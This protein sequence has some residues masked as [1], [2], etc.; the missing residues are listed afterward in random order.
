MLAFLIRW[1]AANR[2]WVIGAAILLA[3]LG[4]WTLPR[5]QMDAI[6]D[7]SE[8]QVIVY[9][10]WEQPPGLV[11][12]QI[13]YPLT[14]ALLGAPKVTSVRGFSDSGFALIY[15]L[16]EEGTDLYWARS[17]ITELL[18]K[19]NSALPAGARVEMGPDATGVGWIYQYALVDETGKRSLADL[20]SIQDSSLRYALQATPGV[21][22]IATVGGFEKEYQ[23]VVQPNALEQYNV[24]FKA[25]VEAV[26]N[27][28]MDTGGRQIDFS[29][30][31]FTVRGRGLA[32]TIEDL[33]RAVVYGQPA[34][35]EM[36]AGSVPLLL[37][38][39]AHIELVPGSREGVSDLNGK[40][41]AV[42]GVVVMRHDQNARE[43]IG[44]V[45]ERLQTLERSLPSG[46]RVVTTYDR[47]DLIHRS[48][49][50][51]L[52][53][54]FLATCVVS[55]I[56]LTFLRHFPSALVAVSVIPATLLIAL[57]PMYWLG[58]NFNIMS[59]GGIV[60]SVGVLVDGAIIAVENVHRRI[61]LSSN[62]G[63][64]IVRALEEVTPAI[65]LSL[66]LV[67]VTF[68]PIFALTGPEGRLF[69][70]LAMTKTIVMATAAVMTITFVPALRMLLRSRSQIG[71]GRSRR[72][73]RSPIVGKTALYE[74]AVRFV[75]R[76]PKT[77]IVSAVLLVAATIP[78]YLRLGREFMPPLNEGTVLYMPTMLPGVS[79]AQALEIL[80]RQDA[81]LAAFPEVA[82]TFGKAGRAETATDPAAMSMI[83]TTLILKPHEQW[84]EQPQWYSR[85]SPEWLKNLLFRRI[86]SDRI[87]YEDLISAMD[88]A[89]AL[90]G[91]ANSWTMPIRGRTDMLTTGARTPVAVK[92]FGPDL[93]KTQEVGE[94]VEAILKK[95]PG[96]RSAFAERAEEGNYLDIQIDRDRLANRGLQVAEV[97][98]MIAGA[99]GGAAVTEI[100]EERSRYP[101]T[102]RYPKKFRDNPKAIGGITI[103]TEN[104]ERVTLQEIA[105]IRKVRGIGMIRTENGMLASYVFID[106]DTN[107]IGKYVEAAQQA[108]SQGMVIPSGYSLQWSGEYENMI[109]A[110][111]RLQ[112]VV[113]AT[114]LL[115]FLLLF[116][117]TKSWVKTGMVALAVPFS[118]IGAVWLL[119]ALG[120]NI[121]VATW[122]GMI[123]LVGLDA[124]TGVFMLLFLDLA[125]QEA[126]RNGTLAREGGLANAV[127]EGAAKRLRP[128]LMTV[129]AAFLGLLPTMLSLGAGS[130]VARRIVAPMV[131]GLASS[132]VLELLVYPPLYFLW[133]R[134]SS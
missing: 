66:L 119:Y 133:R 42:G 62:S 71:S 44:R 70:P 61:D 24:S 52:W 11:E 40:G 123:A 83:E 69:Q 17:R 72:V 104:G 100:F 86:G 59:L 102:V 125:F 7:V 3:M 2:F 79:A 80:Q 106:A 37:R 30:R 31:N 43:V 16:F 134:R 47:S 85:W 64:E 111:Q 113:P 95:I 25:V 91:V 90:P 15:V 122:V 93:K 56:I 68:F 94:Q 65:F 120:Y 101:V 76:Y 131:G 98:E 28:T 36:N 103:L 46:V 108:V 23:V 21:A 12:A 49:K 60:L 107:D 27:S 89:V 34:R 55:L 99:I 114:L 81:L 19:T 109:R 128:K 51:L 117:N 87:S 129:S 33:E 54:L 97:Q 73:R 18:T 78:I 1:S 53:E 88:R 115:M 20:R 82:R 14:T 26:R 96:T 50:T 126:R 4:L 6:P 92:I 9:A 29:G 41:E 63:D 118:L 132:F 75:L 32:R 121:S 112:I 116:L 57:G 127:V 130:D 45:K 84:R 22:E 67:T 110:R 58:V 38:D 105:N 124:E 39:L 35:M 48:I 77:T 10:K 8:T 5:Q 13:T 74:S